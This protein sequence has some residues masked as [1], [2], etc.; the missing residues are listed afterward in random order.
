M[1]ASWR[2]DPRGIPRRIVEENY[3]VH[4]KSMTHRAAQAAAASSAGSVR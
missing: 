3:R 4:D 1:L 2:I